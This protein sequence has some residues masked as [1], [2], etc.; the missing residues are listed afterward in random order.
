MAD[1]STQSDDVS[2]KKCG[3]RAVPMVD[4]FFLKRVPRNGELL[5]VDTNVQ[6][7]TSEPRT[8]V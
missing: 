7:I 3:K 1:R 6:L 4:L 8:V 5:L 2:S